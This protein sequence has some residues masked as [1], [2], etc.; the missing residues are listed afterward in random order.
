MVEFPL[1]ELRFALALLENNSIH[2]TRYERYVEPMVY[3]DN[4]TTW[5]EAFLSFK[6]LVENIFNN[7]NQ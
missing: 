7:L 3:A 6:T 4:K 1:D 5:E 2:K